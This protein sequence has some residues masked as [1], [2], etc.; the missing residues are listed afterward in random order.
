MELEI[1]RFAVIGIKM[2]MV[3]LFPMFVHV[4]IILNVK[5]LN[6]FDKTI[7]VMWENNGITYLIKIDDTN[8]LYISERPA[9]II[10]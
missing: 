8:T 5:D 6:M 2:K 1:L 10:R 7:I 9:E 4:K 3:N